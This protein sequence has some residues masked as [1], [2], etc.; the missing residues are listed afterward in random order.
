MKRFV[1]LFQFNLIKKRDLAFIDLEKYNLL[2]PPSNQLSTG[3]D[4][5]GGVRFRN[6]LSLV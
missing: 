4:V 5:I 1:C 2:E 3:V 6:V